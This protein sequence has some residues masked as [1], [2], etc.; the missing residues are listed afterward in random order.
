MPKHLVLPKQTARMTMLCLLSFLAVCLGRTLGV[1]AG[2]AQQQIAQWTVLV[3]LD[4]DNNLEREAVEDF[5]EMASVGSNGDVQIVVQFDRAPGY[6]RRYGDW[7]GTLRFHVTQGMTPEPANAL[8]DLGEANM[9]DGQT[10][11]SFVQ[12]GKAT[13]P[14]QRTSL[15]LTFGT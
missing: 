8:A 6:D 4:G 13:F 11:H 5:L 15:V 1:H 12:W 3:Y 14:A 10:L 7:H 2:D 9:G